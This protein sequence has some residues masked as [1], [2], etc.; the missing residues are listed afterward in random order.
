MDVTAGKY[1]QTLTFVYG[2]TRW[3]LKTICSYKEN[4]QGRPEAYLFT[5][6]HTRNRQMVVDHL[7]VVRYNL[8]PSRRSGS[9]DHQ[10]PEASKLKDGIYDFRY[11]SL[12]LSIEA[13]NPYEFIGSSRTMLKI[14]VILYGIWQWCLEPLWIY[15]V[16]FGFKLMGP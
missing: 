9:V 11:C 2:K 13:Q 15:N 8:D 14:P 7:R 4:G 3:L 10:P 5:W 6:K 16:C 1:M 12:R